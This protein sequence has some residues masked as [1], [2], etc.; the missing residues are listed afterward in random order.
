[1]DFVAATADQLLMHPFKGWFY[2]D[3][4][5]F[6][7]LM[8]ASDLLGDSRWSD[9]CHGFCRAWATRMLPFQK[10]DNTA[11]GSV[12]CAIVERTGDAVLRAAVLDL[13]RHLR[14]RRKVKDVSVTFEDTR[15]A[16]VQP[17]GG[18]ALSPAEQDQMAA[19]GAGIYLDCMHFD[20]PFYAHLSRLDPTGGWAQ[21]AIAEIMGYRHLL[22]N[23]DLAL[24]R[25]FWLENVSR[26]YTDGWG[27][28]QGWALLG[29]IDVVGHL[30]GSVA[31][32]GA[33]KQAAQSLARRMVEFQRED[34]NWHALVHEP[35]SGDEAS[36]A[37]FMATAFYRGMNI[38]LLSEEEFLGPAAKAFAAMCKNVDP[39]GGLRG[40]SAAVMSALVEEHYWHVP[41]AANVPWGQGPLLAAV[42]AAKAHGQQSKSRNAERMTIV[43]RL[44]SSARL[45]DV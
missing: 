20:A 35:R 28:G 38:G 33:V 3:S 14:A 22:F 31:G 30:P 7:G 12:M 24:Y 2:G 29:L 10:F 42:A 23:A 13:A 19:P 41:L 45:P 8:T 43:P 21:M 44:A 32:I 34:G 4:I 16:L 17:Y 39:R 15:I 5:G 36:T 1:M 27:R 37:A 25:H 9:F 11:P 6:E 26:S 18:V 40:V